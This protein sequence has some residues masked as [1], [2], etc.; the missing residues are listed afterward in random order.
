MQFIV[1][2]IP[3]HA[4]SITSTQ[5]LIYAIHDLL[6]AAIPLNDRG[7]RDTSRPIACT[8]IN[9]LIVP[10]H[11]TH[12]RNVRPHV[13]SAVQTRANMRAPNELVAVVDVVDVVHVVRPVVRTSLLPRGIRFNVCA[14]VW[15][16]KP[17]TF[18]IIYT[19]THTHA[20]RL[21]SSARLSGGKML[22]NAKHRVFSVSPRC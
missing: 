18:P 1:E 13:L 22:S 10:P 7:A 14:R 2:V 15:T 6:A 3:I 21:S 9:I 17:G 19:H 5:Q 20:Q 11:A 8:Q 4:R 12:L 16:N